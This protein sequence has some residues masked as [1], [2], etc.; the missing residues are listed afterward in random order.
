MALCQRCQGLL[1]RLAQGMLSR[2][3]VSPGLELCVS[4]PSSPLNGQEALCLRVQPAQGAHNSSAGA[5]VS[6]PGH[7]QPLRVAERGPDLQS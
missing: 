4:D 7:W 3:G 5:W 2:V 1:K 6:L